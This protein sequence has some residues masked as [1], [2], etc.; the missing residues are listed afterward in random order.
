MTNCL[1][2]HVDDSAVRVT[3]GWCLH[4]FLLGNIG[5]AKS[6]HSSRFTS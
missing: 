2:L 6:G 1:G 3:G 4:E 5:L